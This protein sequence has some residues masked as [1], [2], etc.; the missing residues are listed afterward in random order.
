MAPLDKPVLFGFDCGHEHP[1]YSL[2]LGREVT[3]D[4]TDDGG[5]LKFV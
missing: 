2:Y 5:Y 3:L 4:V 1:N